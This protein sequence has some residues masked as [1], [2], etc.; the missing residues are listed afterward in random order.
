MVRYKF[1]LALKKLSHDLIEMGNMAEMAIEQAMSALK[2][3][4]TKLAGE[5]V[6]DDKKVDE[7]ERRI[8][9]SCLK[10]L[11]EQQ[12]VARD[13]REISTA[14]KMV[15]DIERICDQAADIA[16]ISLQLGRREQYVREPD[17]LLKMAAVANKMVKKGIDAYVLHDIEVAEKVIAMDDE[18]DALFDQFREDMI[19]L[20]IEDRQRADEVVDFIMIG[21]YLERIGDHAENIAEWVIFSVTGEHKNERII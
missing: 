9:S 8:E 19:S 1:D 12:P 5:V 7:M 18:M 20:V 2:N 6:A 15:T 17:H 10:L 14:L 16:E 3:H 13:L 4:D 11:L 21:K